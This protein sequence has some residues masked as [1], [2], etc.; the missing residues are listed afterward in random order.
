VIDVEY[1]AW[2]SIPNFPSAEGDAWEPFIDYMEAAHGEFGPVLG[3]ES[4][5]LANLVMST[6]AESPT[7]AAQVLFAAAADGLR[8]V[9]LVDLYP[10]AVK[11]EL[12]EDEPVPA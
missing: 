6:D 2:I 8:A 5:R 4:G 3:W 9:D 1:R 12:A 11:I 10:S 7:E